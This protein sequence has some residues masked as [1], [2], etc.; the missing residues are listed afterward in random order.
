MPYQAAMFVPGG[1]DAGLLLKTAVAAVATPPPLAASV[2][3]AAATASA[4]LRLSP[5]TTTSPSLEGQG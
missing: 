5:C 2:S 4:T 1:P 3:T